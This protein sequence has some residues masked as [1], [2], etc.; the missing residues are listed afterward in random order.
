[1]ILKKMKPHKFADIFPLMN[2]KEYKELKI[3]I[4]EN[5]L[6][7]PIILFEG[8]IL[9]G[10]NRY[11]VCQELKIE[12]KTR[13]YKGKS[14]LQYVISTNLKRRHLNESQRGMIAIEHREMFDEEARKRH[15]NPFGVPQE[16]K[17]LGHKCH[18]P[19]VSYG[20]SRDKLGEAFGIGGR[21][22][23]M[24]KTVKQ[25]APERVGA[26][27]KGEE[28]ISTVYREIKIEEQKKEIEKLIPKKEIKGV[29]DVIV[30]DPPWSYEEGFS[31]Y[32][33]KGKRGVT[34]YPTMDLSEL[35]KI[36]L[37]MAENCVIWLWVTNSMF[38]EAIELTE[39]W[40]LKRKIL[41]TWDKQI[42]GVGNYLRN[43][44]EHCFLCFKGK[45]Y[46]KNTK[47]TTL[48]S[49]KRTTHSTKP[50]IFYKMVD[51]ICVGRKLDY[52][53]R[54]ERKGWD[55]YGNI[56]QNGTTKQEN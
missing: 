56:K 37:P 54:K 14:A 41:L 31:S 47:W 50:E 24:A 23:N 11:N 25:K 2:N 18:H 4:K 20:K 40:D 3:D 29:Y 36:K 43:I 12:Y 46:F 28:K 55:V 13:E 38:K 35:K 49:E 7:E 44:T 8:K 48:I 5:G 21:I 26:I 27:K 17:G 22:I 42:M 51:E 6:L 30:I 10:R 34:D 16:T 1:M 15:D 53:A 39:Y 9:D 52:F 45:P 32:D 33:E 19:F